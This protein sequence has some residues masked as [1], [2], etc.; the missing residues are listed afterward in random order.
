MA[1]HFPAMPGDLGL[2]QL[3]Y[4]ASLPTPGYQP[5]SPL[6]FGTEVETQLVYSAPNIAVKFTFDPTG[7][8]G[9]FDQDT[10]E[11]MIAEEVTAI[12]TVLSGMSGVPLAQVQAQVTVSRAWTWTDSTGYVAGWQDTMPYPPAPA[13]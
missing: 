7:S 5:A 11:A 9:T 8:T 2:F 4:N 13:G 12:C 1:N 6:N 10:V 3:A